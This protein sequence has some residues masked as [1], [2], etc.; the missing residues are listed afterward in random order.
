LTSTANLRKLG[1]SRGLQEQA[2]VGVRVD[3]HA[4]E[5]ARRDGGDRLVEAAFA[6]EEL[7]RFVGT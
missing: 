4:L 5:A 2:A 7:F 3:A 1:R 6:V